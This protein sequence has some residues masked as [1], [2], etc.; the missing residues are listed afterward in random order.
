MKNEIT[1][2]VPVSGDDGMSLNN[3]SLLIPDGALPQSAKVT[4]SH[5][6]QD[7]IHQSI[8]S[9]PW[10]SMLS[11]LTAVCVQCSPPVEQFI[12]P[13]V[14]TITLP[15]D[16]KIPEKSTSLR[17]LQSNYMSSWMDITDEP[18]T[19]ISISHSDRQLTVKTDHSGWFVVAVLQLDISRIIPMAVKSVFSEESILLHVNAFGYIFPDRT[20]AQVS[21]FV[22]PQ[23]DHSSISVDPPPGHKL[24]AFPH[25][26][27]ANKGQKIRLELQ[28]KFD[29][30]VEGGQTDLYSELSVDGIIEG[31][32]EKTVTLSPGANGLYGK[33]IISTYC[34]SHKAWEPI[35]E[36]NLSSATDT[37]QNNNKL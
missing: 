15:S 33:L 20:H 7:E 18:A 31:I 23:V 9:S 27:K 14:I 21:V 22:S 6:N 19:D 3:I 4:L 25:S 35:Q 17:L 34:T 26:F 16:M 36:M 2:E 28:G 1:K 13:V 8:Q 11:I 30:D 29:P 10:A 37:H 12:I 32:V 24:I 5:F